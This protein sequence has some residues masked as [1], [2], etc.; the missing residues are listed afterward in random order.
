M[1]VEFENIPCLVLEQTRYILSDIRINTKI[2][3]N[4]RFIFGYRVL[5][6]EKIIDIFYDD[7]DK[8]YKHL[9]QR[10]IDLFEKIEINEQNR[11]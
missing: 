5:S 1:I 9:S 7:K 10:F 6:G 4:D 3:S 11:K 8:I 2:D